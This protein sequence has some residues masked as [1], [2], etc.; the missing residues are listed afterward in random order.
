VMRETPQL[1]QV[2]ARAHELARRRRDDAPT[3]TRREKFVRIADVLR[4]IA[5][6]QDAVIYGVRREGESR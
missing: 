2:I 5:E 4:A 3:G 1:Q 6:Q